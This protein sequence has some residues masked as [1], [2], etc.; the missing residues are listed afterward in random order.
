MRSNVESK[1]CPKWHWDDTTFLKELFSMKLADN[2]DKPQK[3]FVWTPS[4][5][6]IAAQIELQ[7]SRFPWTSSLARPWQSSLQPW[8]WIRKAPWWKDW[9]PCE[10]KPPLV[11]SWASC[12][13]H[14]TWT[15]R[16]SRPPTISLSF[17]IGKTFPLETDLAE[18]LLPDSIKFINAN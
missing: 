10:H 5:W 14:Q 3:H 9:P 7:S 6:K 16:S 13:S 18:P 2:V 8:P 15:C 4:F 17:F 11:S 12:S 1:K